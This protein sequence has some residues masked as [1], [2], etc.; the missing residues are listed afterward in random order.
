MH[1]ASPSGTA[2]PEETARFRELWQDRVRRLLA[3]ADDSQLVLVE[4]A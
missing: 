1:R 3:G 2:T 4:P